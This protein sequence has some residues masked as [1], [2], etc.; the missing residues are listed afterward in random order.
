MSE[1]P[2]GHGGHTANSEHRGT[3]S[4]GSRESLRVEALNDGVALGE[5]HPA[6]SE[7][8]KHKRPT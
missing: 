1:I 8:D 7:V 3:F 4:W 6:R 5:N 2:A